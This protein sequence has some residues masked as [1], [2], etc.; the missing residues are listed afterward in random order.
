M[1]PRNDRTMTSNTIVSG[2]RVE[3]STIDSHHASA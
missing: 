2:G 3:K 1:D